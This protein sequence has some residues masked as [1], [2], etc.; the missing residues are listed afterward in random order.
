ME[1]PL[2]R[3]GRRE[4]TESNLGDSTKT[5]QGAGL[6][7][8]LCGGRTAFALF[9]TVDAS[10]AILNTSRI[11]DPR[12]GRPVQT[13]T[14]SKLIRP[15]SSRAKYASICSRLVTRW[16]YAAAR[17]RSARWTSSSRGSFSPSLAA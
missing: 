17:T 5:A 9:D 15:S 16:T 13:C 6:A 1:G 11:D 3:G 2:V 4:S 7:P 10:L 14:A 12:P 8:A